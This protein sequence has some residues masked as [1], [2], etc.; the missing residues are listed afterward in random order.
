MD[1]LEKR[2]RHL[3]WEVRMIANDPH[4]PVNNRRHPRHKQWVATLNLIEA[5]GARTLTATQH[6]DEDLPELFSSTPSTYPGR[7]PSPDQVRVG[8]PLDP[9]TFYSRVDP[10]T[11]KAPKQEGPQV[12]LP[13]L[14]RREA[15]SAPQVDAVYPS[16]MPSVTGL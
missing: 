1:I 15:L 3:L 16:S 5:H 13:P 4:H 8:A 10:Q 2:L 6:A 7:S 11:R 9:F 12:A 14:F